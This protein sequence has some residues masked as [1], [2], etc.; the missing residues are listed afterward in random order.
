M[1]G[2]ELQKRR[3]DTQLKHAELQQRELGAAKASIS[4]LTDVIL[5]TQ[6]IE[7]TRTSLALPVELLASGAKS[8]A[9]VAKPQ[10]DFRKYNKN[11]EAVHRAISKA[12]KCQ[13]GFTARLQPPSWA[14]FCSRAWEICGHHSRSG[15]MIALRTYNIVPIEAPIIDFV[16][17]GDTV[18][19]QR[20]LAERKATPFDRSQDGFTLLDVKTH[21]I[22]VFISESLE[23]L[24]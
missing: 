20:L 17:Q 8:N 12:S 23:E 14:W 10:S 3:H 4:L 1:V 16:K 22:F 13:R 6:S 11:I 21:S 5:A 9:A 2:R 7:S 18:S 19:V 15:W 24:T